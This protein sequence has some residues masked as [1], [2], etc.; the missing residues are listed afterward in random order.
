M[1]GIGFKNMKVFKENQWFDFKDIT[2]SELEALKQ[3]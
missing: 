2:L 3:T 1:K